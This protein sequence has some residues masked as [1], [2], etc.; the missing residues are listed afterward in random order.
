MPANLQKNIEYHYYQSGHMVYAHQ[1][2][3]KEMH[4]TVAQFIRSTSNV[5]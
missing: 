5:K 2:S 1:D 4:D 3:L